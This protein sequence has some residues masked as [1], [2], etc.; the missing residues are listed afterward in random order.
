MIIF[1]I[2]AAIIVYKKYLLTWHLFDTYGVFNFIGMVFLA[3]ITITIEY[4]MKILQ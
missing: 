1:P 4:K 3:L 2:F